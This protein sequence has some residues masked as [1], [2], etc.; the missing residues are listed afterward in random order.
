MLHAIVFSLALL[1]MA[2]SAHA[3]GPWID[4][5]F[6]RM[7]ETFGPAVVDQMGGPTGTA[8]NTTIVLNSCNAGTTCRSF[9][10][11]S[12][13]IEVPY[14]AY[15]DPVGLDLRYSA[16]V[17]PSLPLPTNGDDIIHVSGYP[18]QHY[19]LEIS[20]ADAPNVA[21]CS[22]RGSALKTVAIAGGP[23]LYDGKWHNLECRVIHGGG[24][25]LELWVDAILVASTRGPIGTI[26]TGTPMLLGRHSTVPDAGLFTGR[27]DDVRIRTRMP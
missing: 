9:N 19:K 17:K 14:G 8:F 24:D 3:A 2:A 12:S 26:V 23:N 5:G 25:Q 1:T 6:W 18:A 27:M 4:R 11:T 16:F 10:G 15:A 13:Y 20:E 22:V 21:K 7:N